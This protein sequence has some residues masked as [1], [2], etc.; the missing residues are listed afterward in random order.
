MNPTMEGKPPTQGEYYCTSCSICFRLAAGPLQ[1]P[2]CLDAV[3]DDFV[4]IYVREVPE[5][6]TMHTPDDFAG[7]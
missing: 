3:R 5:E 4:L 7:G 6:E 1:C 2:Q